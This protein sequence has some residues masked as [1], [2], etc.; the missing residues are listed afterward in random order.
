MF[1]EGWLVKTLDGLAELRQRSKPWLYMRLFYTE[2][3]LGWHASEDFWY[4]HMAFTFAL[5]MGV[6]LTFL[7]FVKGVCRLFKRPYRYLDIASVMVLV[8]ITTPAFTALV[9]MAGKHNIKPLNGVERMDKHGCCTQA[10][11]FPRY[12]AQA[13]IDFLTTRGS[14]QTDSLIEEYAETFGHDR[15]ALAPQVVQH[16]G[17]VSSH[18]NLPINTQ[19]TWA[20]WFEAQDSAKL[21]KE[22]AKLL[23][24]S[25]WRAT[26]D[27]S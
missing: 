25:I 20:F 8:L 15:Y 16:V 3:S 23:R 5:A 26:G 21:K 19:S 24:S 10:L 7:L 2:T 14:G 1:A 12:Q 11:I 27:G 22:H 9:F 13:L 6:V 18:K 4:D 17:S